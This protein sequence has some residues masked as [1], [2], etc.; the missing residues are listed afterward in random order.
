MN[1]GPIME[2]RQGGGGCAWVGLIAAAFGL[3]LATAPLTHT[4]MA[5]IICSVLGCI[6]AVVGII[7]AFGH[8]AITIDRRNDQVLDAMYLGMI[9]IRRRYYDFSIFR[10]VTISVRVIQGSDEL[11]L[12]DVTL[13]GRD[14]AISIKAESWSDYAQAR[15]EA[16]KIARFLEVSIED[17]TRTEI[18]STPFEELNLLLTERVSANG[19]CGTL[20]TI[21]EILPSSLVLSIEEGKSELT[22]L[23]EGVTPKLLVLI[24][25]CLLFFT[26]V[27]WHFVLPF[28]Q[29]MGPETG[30]PAIVGYIFWPFITLFLASPL[31]SI[32]EGINESFTSECL[33][34]DKGQFTVETNS[35]TKT[36]IETMELADI[37]DV[38]I[39]NSPTSPNTGTVIIIGAGEVLSIGSHL[40]ADDRKQ[41]ATVVRRLV[42]DA[43]R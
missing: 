15:I 13:I 28:S 2:Y 3:I 5:S 32:G 6:F 19:Q 26:V 43:Q 27:L 40:T 29:L 22:V 10:A 9:P 35:L 17:H 30:T 37:R 31:F 14:E 39:N 18:E 34:I 42:I 36:T 7:L 41:L 8:S 21:R 23:E 25:I 4:W 11:V 33:S 12:Y 16:E 24:G 20:P 38:V 1:K